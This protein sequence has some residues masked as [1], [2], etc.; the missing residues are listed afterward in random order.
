MN[1]PHVWAIHH[2]HGSG[3]TSQVFG[4]RHSLVSRNMH[5]RNNT[6][7]KTV[8]V[9]FAMLWRLRPL[10]RGSESVSRF[11]L[12]MVFSECELKGL[13]PAIC[14]AEGWPSIARTCGLF[15]ICTVP[16]RQVRY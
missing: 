5:S 13:Q 11:K 2:M 10:L 9:Y 14:A 3:A 1:S 7:A 8:V 6:T 16:G 12:A 4:A 15:T